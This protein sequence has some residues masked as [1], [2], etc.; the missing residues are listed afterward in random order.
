MYPV[1]LS[2]SLFLHIP[3]RFKVCNI[4]VKTAGLVANKDLQKE[5]CQRDQMGGGKGEDS[6][7]TGYST[8]GASE[9]L[10]ESYRRTSFDVSVQITVI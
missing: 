2:L 9:E 5:E 4:P 1:S 6:M 10:V 7:F 8:E 3:T